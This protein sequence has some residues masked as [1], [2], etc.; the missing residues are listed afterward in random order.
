MLTDKTSASNVALRHFAADNSFFVSSASGAS[1]SNDGLS[2]GSAKATI[3]GALT[4]LGSSPGTVTVGYG[5]FSLAAGCRLAAGQYVNG[6]GQALTT[7]TVANGTTGMTPFLIQNV[8]NAG[9]HDLTLNCNKA[10]TTSGSH[11]IYVNAGNTNMTGIDIRRVNVINSPQSG[12]AV[13][14]YP[15]TYG[16]GGIIEDATTT[17]CSGTGGIYLSGVAAFKVIRPVCNSN[18]QSGLYFGYSSDFVVTD[19]ECNGNA[20]HGLTV[21]YA[22]SDFKINSGNF[23][24]ST[25]GYGIAVSIACTNFTI[26]SPTCNSNYLGGISVDVQ[27]ESQPG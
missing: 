13:I 6:I 12:I 4:A 11:G 1:D 21:N 22:S 14:A 23:N 5:A 19:A 18:A 9:L 20:S 26:T 8:S 2:W 25:A 27:N 16:I 10:N 3:A 15:A 24:N 7:I 17:G